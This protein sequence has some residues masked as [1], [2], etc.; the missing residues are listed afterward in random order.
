M[1]DTTSR[2][3]GPQSNNTCHENFA[4]SEVSVGWACG[5]PVGSRH[6]TTSRARFRAPRLDWRA[7]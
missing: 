2:A 3:I 4:V 7:C 1:V 6:A 5:K